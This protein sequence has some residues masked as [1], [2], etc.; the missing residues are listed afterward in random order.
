M[1]DELTPHTVLQPFVLP[2]CAEGEHEAFTEP[3][4]PNGE[5]SP[6]AELNSI[7]LG[8][9]PCLHDGSPMFPGQT[10][11]LSPPQVEKYVA[12][13][14]VAPQGAEIETRTSYVVTSTPEPA[15][16]EPTPTPVPDPIS[17]PTPAPPVG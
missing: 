16:S 8:M 7:S 10:V 6:G 12:A 13:G 3:R 14:V 1:S 17:V 9:A 2:H 5:L 4:E 15:I 11:H